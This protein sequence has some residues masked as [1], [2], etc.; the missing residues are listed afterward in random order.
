[1]ERLKSFIEKI[2]W[3]ELTATF[4]NG[5]DALIHI[6]KN[7]PALTFLDINLGE[8]SGIR[9]LET[10]IFPGKVI[11]TTAYHEYALKA[12]DLNVIDY[13]LKPFTFEM[14]YQAVEKLI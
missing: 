6:K 14:F 10:N 2:D 1:M 4:D 11:L 3:L 13:L 8:I 7:P 9:M 12:F 5:I